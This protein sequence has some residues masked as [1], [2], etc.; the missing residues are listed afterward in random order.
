MW[1]GY[2]NGAYAMSKLLSCL[3]CGRSEELGTV[4]GIVLCAEC[5]AEMYTT[6]VASA[7]RKLMDPVVA[8]T[9]HDTSISDE[10]P[11]GILAW[12]AQEK[13]NNPRT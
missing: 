9:I 4:M 1:H 8:E 3:K 7:V 11:M 5:Y 10:E 2:G 12:G 6:A 13:A